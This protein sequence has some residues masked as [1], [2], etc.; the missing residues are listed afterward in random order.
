MFS[1]KAFVGINYR[2]EKGN[3]V[4]TYGS[5]KGIAKLRA[6]LAARDARIHR[7]LREEHMLPSSR[8][9]QFSAWLGGSHC[10]TTEETIEAK[11]AKMISKSRF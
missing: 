6:K 11:V 8:T 2:D 3:L 9:N 1:S 7:E 4:T 5:P 10:R